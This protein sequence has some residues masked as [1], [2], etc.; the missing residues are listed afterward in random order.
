MSLNNILIFFLTLLR[1]KRSI[2]NMTGGIMEIIILSYK[3]I[4]SV[5][6]ILN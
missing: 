6:I 5:D 4:T 3:N 2:E 1:F